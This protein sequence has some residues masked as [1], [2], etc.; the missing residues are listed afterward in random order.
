MVVNCPF[1]FPTRVYTRRL[2]K[3]DKKNDLQKPVNDTYT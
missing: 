3:D 2:V 1:Y